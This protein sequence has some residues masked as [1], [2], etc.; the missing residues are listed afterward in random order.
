MELYSSAVSGDS[1]M[2]THEDA[3]GVAF[4]PGENGGLQGILGPGV[5]K[6]PISRPRPPAEPPSPPVLSD[7]CFLS[8]SFLGSGD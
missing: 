7:L 8:W 1:L 3:S 4:E 5:K 6:K 2:I